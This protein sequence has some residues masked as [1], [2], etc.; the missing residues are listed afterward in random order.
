MRSARQTPFC[1]RPPCANC[2]ASDASAGPHLIARAP[3]QRALFSRLTDPA[4]IRISARSS[5]GESARDGSIREVRWRRAHSSN[6]PSR[7]RNVCGCEALCSNTFTARQWQDCCPKRSFAGAPKLVRISRSE[8]ILD[9]QLDSVINTY[10]QCSMERYV[11][12]GEFVARLR[13]FGDP[14]Q[15][16]PNL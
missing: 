14:L 12:P 11:D 9:K 3:A 16:A 1:S 2:F 13:Y 5:H 4:T 7:H 10:M 8:R 15:R 6:L